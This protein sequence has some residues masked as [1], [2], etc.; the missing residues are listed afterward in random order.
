M[1]GVSSLRLGI[2]LAVVLSGC[3]HGGSAS[4]TLPPIGG[5]NAVGTARTPQSIGAPVQ[6]AAGANT[7]RN[8]TASVSL[9]ATPRAGDVLLVAVSWSADPASPVVPV[10]PPAGWTLVKRLDHNP[11]IGIAVYSRIATGAESRTLAWNV[12]NAGD[13]YSI[14]LSAKEFS[15]VDTTK[16]VDV[17]ATKTLETT[18]SMSLSATPTRAGDLGVAYFGQYY[19]TPN[20]PPTNFTPGTG[21]TIDDQQ[22]GAGSSIQA[23]SQTRNALN[24]GT[25]AVTAS[26]SYQNGENSSQFG[27]LVLLEAPVGVGNGSVSLVQGARAATATGGATSI[28]VSLPAAPATGNVLLASVHW[29]DYTAETYDTFQT[30]PG[31]TRVDSVNDIPADG[32]AVFAKAVQSGDTAG[33]YTF[34]T[35]NDLHPFV[36]TLDEVSGADVVRPANVWFGAQ[37][38][39]GSSQSISTNPNPTV[40]NGLAIAYFNQ[41][42][43]GS[44]NPTGFAPSSGYVLRASMFDAD[45]ELAVQELVGTTG[46]T[47]YGTVTASESWQNGANSSMVAEIVV[48]APKP[49]A[50]ASGGPTYQS[51]PLF[52][53]GNPINTDVSAYPVDPNSANYITEMTTDYPSDPSTGHPRRTTLYPE[54]GNDPM[55]GPQGTPIN[56]VSSLPSQYAAFT[57]S[58]YGYFSDHGA[59]PIPNG[60]RIE[61]QQYYGTSNATDHHMSVL[62]T[63]NCGLYEFYY[64]DQPQAPWSAAAND[65]WNL[66]SDV[67]RPEGWGTTDAAGLPYF[68]LLVRGDE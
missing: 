59:V 39:G 40:G 52:S 36:A 31:W 48:L 20:P 35:P 33:P 47:A 15:G 50:V 16:P 3:G 32:I 68:P 7:T 44:H 64:V 61:K 6:T 58:V 54:F 34:A 66:G 1:R 14:A 4:S 27:V 65:V 38:E 28:S 29:A 42:N 23:Q 17:V 60:A 21:W 9:T 49:P 62:N 10:T 26:E 11:D 30:P 13:Q 67:I 55:A 45:K 43:G 19:E 2:A 8:N 24:S 25:S 56:V 51:C 22:H 53:P 37:Q 63:A 46:T 57:D 18:R 5:A 12:G 41:Y